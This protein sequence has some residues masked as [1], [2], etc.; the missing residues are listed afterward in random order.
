ML[1]A[2]WFPRTRCLLCKQE[3]TL[4]ATDT[5]VRR[6]RRICKSATWPPFW[7][8]E[9]VIQGDEKL[10]MLTRNTPPESRHSHGIVVPSVSRLLVMMITLAMRFI[11]PTYLT[12]SISRKKVAQKYRHDRTVPGKKDDRCQF[13]IF[14]SQATK[15][16]LDT[17]QRLNPK[18]TSP[19]PL[20]ICTTELPSSSFHKR[21]SKTQ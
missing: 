2:E 3:I 17:P 11:Y 8:S 18:K 5:L 6:K 4:A 15:K 12:H 13:F 20:E 9:I 14:T 10:D 1:S 7:R 16:T 21:F 19:R